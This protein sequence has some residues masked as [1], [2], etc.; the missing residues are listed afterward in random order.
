ME[1]SYCQNC[2]IVLPVDASHFFQSKLDKLSSSL[3]ESGASE[4]DLEL[5]AEIR[6][7][8]AGL[9]PRS[10]T[11]SS[12]A[13]IR[14]LYEITSDA[15]R[16]FDERVEDLLRMGCERFNLPVGV[17]A[18]ID[19]MDYII[20]TAVAPDNAV[21]P[22]QTFDVRETYCSVAVNT[23]EP[24]C[25][26][27]AGS[28]NW[29]N[30][31]AY[32]KFH[33]ETYLGVCVRVSG[34]LYGALAFS[35]I[36]PRKA[37]FSNADLTL[38]QLMSRWIGLELERAAY[39]AQAESAR[40]RAEMAST[41]KSEFLANMSHEI[42]TPLNSV[43]GFSEL[44]EREI[45]NPRH[46]EYLDAINS[47][48]NALLALINDI[49]DLSKIEAGRMELQYEPVRLTAL[50]RT[51]EN[52]FKQKARQKGIELRISIDPGLPEWL[53]LDE[54]RVRQ[55]LFNLIGNALKF[56]ERGFV[57]LD[58]KP[59]PRSGME[60][61]IDLIFSV[62]DTGIG[63]PAADQE[64]IFAAFEQQSGQ[65][66][67]KYGGTG[68]GLAITTRLVELMDGHISL[69]STPGVGS[70]FSVLLQGVEPM[71]GAVQPVSRH[72]PNSD[73]PDLTG[74]QLLV[75]DDNYVNRQ[76]LVT[77]LHSTQAL[78]QEAESGA[79]ALAIAEARA[80]DMI[81]LD[82]RMP[83]MDGVEVLRRLRSNSLTAGI[84]TLIVTADAL[85]KD[86]ELLKNLGAELLLKPLNRPRLM[87]AIRE[88]L[89]LETQRQEET[90]APEESGVTALASE[91]RNDVLTLL[92]R[93]ALPLWR[94]TRDT[95][96]VSKAE[97]LSR[98]LVRA[99]AQYHLAALTKL[100]SALSAAVDSYDVEAMLG[101]LEDFSTLYER[102]KAA[103]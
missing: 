14:R 45:T 24:L 39:L 31:P 103:E 68:L 57:A 58:F 75:V 50:T 90:A 30:H 43:L 60:G 17:L 35:D 37:R 69:V 46:R 8:A 100:G 34:K 7:D 44:L 85:F 36:T 11:L 72:D 20:R 33:M 87:Q 5:L 28:T 40:Q 79:K 52:M 73:V 94:E 61:R 76:L 93:E 81:F 71:G 95:L 59:S 65:R 70:T 55:V 82:L 83:D 86:K 48:G 98:C 51:V 97:E 80:P 25:L 42:R 22:G 12:E 13:S 2:A 6:E 54:I 62:S 88:R 4:A 74:Y 27:H 96:A 26:I 9:E 32:V 41:A 16:Q 99:G 92:E 84:P 15:E 10:S 64:R 77:L 63:I 101:R 23:N 29:M 38:I 3:R 18:Q 78:V 47:S 56:T 53:V 19:G 49:L 102:W 89:G 1:A 91:H 67:R 66:E 21:M